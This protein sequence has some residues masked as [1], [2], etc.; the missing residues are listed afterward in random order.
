MY[1]IRNVTNMVEPT[2][3]DCLPIKVAVKEKCESLMSFDKLLTQ[4]DIN[5]K[6]IITKTFFRRKQKKKKKILK[7]F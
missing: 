3:K 1:C 5:F 2:K 4:Q 7:H 6:H